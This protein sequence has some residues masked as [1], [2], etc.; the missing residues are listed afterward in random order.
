MTVTVELLDRCPALDDLTVETKSA[1]AGVA[2][3]IR[4]DEGGRL[5]P[6]VDP[7]ERLLILM[8]GLAKMAAVS[9]DGIERVVYVFKPGEI[10]GSRILSDDAFETA[11]EVVAMKT[12]R[13]IAVGRQALERVGR[14]H[15]EVLMAVTRDL[16]RRLDAMAGRMLEAMSAE[17]PRRL[18][19][20][21]LDFVEANDRSPGGD[22]A[23]LSYPL[24]HELMA[25]IIGA[26]RPHTSTVLGDLEALDAVRRR[27]GRGLLVRPDRLSEIMA[28]REV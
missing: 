14:D 7:P 8:E 20:L 27:K 4:F 12:V 5:V 25:Q 26:S 17:V 10:I 13:A 24:T 21:L 3:E 28:N 23:P 18:C 1:L 2:R 22:L 9:D 11:F 6:L 16:S 19:Q 15:P